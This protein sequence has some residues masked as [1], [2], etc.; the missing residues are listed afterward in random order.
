M[1]LNLF[2]IPET[3]PVL[4]QFLFYSI[5]FAIFLFIFIGC[6]L[7]PQS[8]IDYI[9]ENNEC[10]II[11]SRLESLHNYLNKYHQKTGAY[12]SRL[13]DFCENDQ[14]LQGVLD[15]D[16][17]DGW[18]FPFKYTLLDSDTCLIEINPRNKRCQKPELFSTK[19][20]S[21]INTIDSEK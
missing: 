14:V 1:R 6:S 15:C 20:K 7:M 3:L 19:L 10:I 11:K 18:G 17:C 5:M 16:I 13:S 12:P 2:K 21:N 8:T 9:P 4:F